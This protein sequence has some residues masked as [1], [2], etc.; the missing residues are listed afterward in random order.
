MSSRTVSKFAYVMLPV[1][2]RG[3]GRVIGDVA[4]D[5]ILEHMLIYCGSLQCQ[6]SGPEH[7]A[8][9]LHFLSTPSV[10]MASSDEYYVVEV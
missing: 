1:A 7:L 3:E 2:S 9:R 5:E 4:L 6:C 10:I 8:G